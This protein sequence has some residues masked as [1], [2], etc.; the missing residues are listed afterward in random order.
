MAGA[1]SGVTKVGEI[2]G[3]GSPK[4]FLG[5]G[6]AGM[7]SACL[8]ARDKAAD[9]HGQTLEILRVAE[10]LL[11]E[12]TDGAFQV[13]MAQVWLLDMA[14]LDGFAAAWQQWVGDGPAPAL[15]VVG[16]P[17]AGRTSLVEIRLYATGS[18]P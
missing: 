5:S 7:Y 16:A 13:A 3:P 6:A 1:L 9:A 14:E 10:E 12:M 8:T 17:A 4:I 15:S 2:S 18:A 11:A